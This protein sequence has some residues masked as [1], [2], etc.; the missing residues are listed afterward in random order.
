MG[1]PATTI[2]R[3]TDRD[4]ISEWC[5]RSLVLSDQSQ[6]IGR[7]DN[8]DG[9]LKTDRNTIQPC[10]RV[11]IPD[12]LSLPGTNRRTVDCVW[13]L[14]KE[15]DRLGSVCAIDISSGCTRNTSVDDNSGTTWYHNG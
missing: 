1:L 9:R 6:V 12:F 14:G 8:G 5:V 10:K 7:Y 2:G 3:K 4:Y 15:G 13:R 11:R